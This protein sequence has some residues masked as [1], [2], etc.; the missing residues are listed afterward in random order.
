MPQ[1]RE[2]YARAV[3][4]IEQGTNRRMMHYEDLVKLLTGEFAVIN[5]LVPPGHADFLHEVLTQDDA[6]AR[7]RAW[8]DEPRARPNGSMR[9]LTREGRAWLRQADDGWPSS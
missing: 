2:T 1:V 7:L 3:D 4:V 5:P 6:L 9:A 8:P